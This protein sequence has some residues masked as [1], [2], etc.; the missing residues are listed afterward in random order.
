MI[1]IENFSGKMLMTNQLRNMVCLNKEGYL[2]PIQ[3]GVRMNVMI[4]SG[5]Q[6]C[7]VMNFKLKKTEACVLLVNKIGKI[8]GM[9]ESAEKFFDK[10]ESFMRYNKVFGRVFKVTKFKRMTFVHIKFNQFKK[11]KILSF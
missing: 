7:G 8:L 6:F 5:V 10:G 1:K 11:F 4:E 9:T 3:L 2:V